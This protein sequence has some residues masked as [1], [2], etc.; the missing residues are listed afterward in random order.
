MQT[1]DSVR[2]WDPLV[3]IFH[4]TL[5]LG[6]AA[7][8]LTGDEKSSLHIWS[9]YIVAGL[10]AFRVIWGLVGTPH[11]RFADFV[12]GPATVWRYSKAVLSG[13]PARYLGHNPLGGAMVVAL[14]LSLTGVSVTGLL[15]DGAEEGAAPLAG[16]I[17]STPAVGSSMVGWFPTAHADEDERHAAAGH[18]GAGGEGG[19]EDGVLEEAHEFFANLTLLLVILHIGGVILAS[20]QHRENLIRAMLTGRKPSQT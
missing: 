7:A 9:G 10:V 17:N 18:E 4:W 1:D 19:H 15:L 3:R 6:F 14:L 16:S 13:H 11:A 12:R 8:Y 20:I 5:V 2:V